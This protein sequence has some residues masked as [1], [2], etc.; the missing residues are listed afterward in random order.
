MSLKA[1][2]PVRAC[3]ATERLP[4]GA[5]EEIVAVEYEPHEE[6]LLR[7]YRP[8]L[9]SPDREVRDQAVQELTVLHEFRALCPGSRMLTDPEQRAKRAEWGEDADGDPLP[10]EEPTVEEQPQPIQTSLIAPEGTG[11]FMIPSKARRLLGE[12]ERDNET[13]LP[14]PGANR[15][16]QF[17]DPAASGAPETQRQAAILAYYKTGSDRLRVLDAIARSR[18]DGLTDFEIE[19]EFAMKHQTASARRND[20]MKDGWIEDSGKRRETDTGSKAAVWILSEQGRLE[21]R[22]SA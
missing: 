1:D 20:L 5:P 10:V 19:Q 16:G 4:E 14:D 9:S 18:D 6:A 22:A 12:V 8:M 7:S 15:I 17:S 13:A 11:N 21:W 3:P 2:W